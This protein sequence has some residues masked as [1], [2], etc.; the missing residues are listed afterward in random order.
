MLNVNTFPAAFYRNRVVFGHYFE[1]TLY[2][3]RNLI[4]PSLFL[5]AA[6]VLAMSPGTSSAGVQT[7]TTGAGATDTVGEPVSAQADFTT[8]AG[9]ITISLQNLIVNQNSVGQN[10]SDLYFTVSGTITSP[11]ISSSSS[12]LRTVSG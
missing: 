6:A 5:I 12:T 8:G 3:M 7:F 9:T 2:V 10:V 11:T 1:R 4:S